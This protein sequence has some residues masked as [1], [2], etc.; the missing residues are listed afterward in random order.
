MKVIPIHKGG[1]TQDVNNFRPIALLSIFDKILEKLMHVRLYK[2]LEDNNILYE[3]QFG[4]RKKNSTVHA[5]IQI[6]EKIRESIDQ[7]K[8]GCGIFIELREAFD[9]V[10]HEILL[11]KLEHYGVRGTIL[12][13]FE[14][15]LSGRKQYVFFNGESSELKPTTCGVPQGSVLGPLLFLIYIN[16]LPNIS[17]KLKFFLFADDTNIY[18][19]A[20]NLKTLERVVNN[21]LQWLNHWLNV[22]RLSLNISK[23][24]FVIFHPFNKPIKE[25]ITIKINKKAISEEKY[26]KY[27]GVL[28]DSSLSWKPHIDNLTKKVSRAI[29]IMYK[30]RYYVNRKLLMNLYYSLIYPHLLY[31]IQVWG[32]SF[33][34]NIN[35]L[36]VLQKKVVRLITFQ[37]KFYDYRGPRAHTA[38]LFKEL[39]ILKFEDVFVLRTVQ[40]IHDCLNG[41][42]PTLFNSW[43]KLTKDVHKHTTRSITQTDDSNSESIVN[44]NIFIPFVSTTYYGLNSIK[45]SGVKLWNKTPYKSIRI[46]VSHSLYETKMKKFLLS[47]Y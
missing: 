4:F 25:L 38:P 40:F 2:F 22:N 37:D 47:T 10:N 29:G 30:I 12:K 45:V 39:N 11:R 46:I 21:E 9:T 1:S 33:K 35:K 19:E 44:N 27:L 18:Y 16:D 43:F 41:N 7:G 20:D 5:L 36:T 14:S 24:N 32:S 13:W 31:A 28:I 42:A 6:T 8:F 17:K 15:Y 23:T 34:I 3:N 26:V